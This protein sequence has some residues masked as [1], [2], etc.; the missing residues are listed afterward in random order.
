MVLLL[1]LIII[2]ILTM[3]MI[4]LIIIVIFIIGER[5]WISALLFSLRLSGTHVFAEGLYLFNNILTETFVCACILDQET[6]W[7]YDVSVVIQGPPTK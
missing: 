6:G 5:T 1:L 4:T 7:K 2:M 3:I